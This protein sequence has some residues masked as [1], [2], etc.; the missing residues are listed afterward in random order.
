[1]NLEDSVLI[2][3]HRAATLA[4]R[5]GIAVPSLDLN[6]ASQRIGGHRAEEALRR[7]RQ[8]K[9]VLHVRKDLVILPDAT[10]RTTVGLPELINVVAPTKHLITGGR[11]LEERRLTNQHSFSVIVLVPKVITNFSL[12][13]ENAVFLATEVDRI[14]GWQRSGPHFAFPE[15]ALVDAVSHPRYGVSL[16]MAVG[17]LDRAVGQDPRFLGRLVGATR[18]YRS[19]ATARRIG[20]LVERLF[21]EEAA[22]PFEGLIGTNRTPVLLRAGGAKR[23]QLNERWRVIVNATADLEGANA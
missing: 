9:R 17:A 11:A 23:G 13:R 16:S 2:D 4:G 5:P 21:G 14:W 19:P 10:G 1:M 6:L 7:L 3:L 20:L 12:R 18:R 22:V 8:S 15:R